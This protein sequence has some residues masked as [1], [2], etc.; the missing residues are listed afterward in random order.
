MRDS[1]FR[2]TH[3]RQMVMSYEIYGNV[4]VV[5]EFITFQGTD[6]EVTGVE[7]GRIS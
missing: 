7:G 3:T 6:V 5:G 2:R 1:S 4:N